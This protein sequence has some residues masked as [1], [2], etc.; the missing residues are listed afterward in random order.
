M[1]FL[2]INIIHSIIDGRVFLLPDIRIDLN[3]VLLFRLPSPTVLILLTEP[4]N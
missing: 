3:T 4:D 2:Q 1:T